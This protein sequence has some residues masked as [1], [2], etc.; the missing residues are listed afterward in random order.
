MHAVGPET[1]RDALRPATG[2]RVPLQH[3]VLDGELRDPERCGE[4]LPEIGDLGMPV[5]AAFARPDQ[6]GGIVV[7]RG[8]LAIA[9]QQGLEALGVQARL[10]L[11]TDMRHIPGRCR[12]GLGLVP[13]AAL[14]KPLLRQRARRGADLQRDR[15][16]VAHQPFVDDAVVLADAVGDGAG[17]HARAGGPA[18]AALAQMRHR[19]DDA[20]RAQETLQVVARLD[21][22][23]GQQAAVGEH[24]QR[25]PGAA[26]HIRHGSADRHR[27]LHDAR[28]AVVGADVVDAPAFPDA[29]GDDA[30]VVVQVA[31]FR[32][33]SA[34]ACRLVDARN[35]CH[36]VVCHGFPLRL[37]RRRVEPRTTSLTGS[38]TELL[39]TL[40]SIWSSSRAAVASIMASA[41]W[42][43]EVSW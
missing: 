2:G 9:A 5:P 24:R 15:R 6:V 8:H 19:R 41:S 33:K 13:A 20:V 21:H 29:V 14:V 17:M 16:L 37:L 4:P 42:S 27:C 39:C 40:P 11:R 28:V 30:D 7:Q 23:L 3:E 35:R 34:H 38:T 26:D 18:E 22:V 43:T 10:R 32:R 1:Q 36:G 25:G 31:E 12:A